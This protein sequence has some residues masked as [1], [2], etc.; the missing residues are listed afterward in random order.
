VRN[1]HGSSRQAEERHPTASNV[2]RNDSEAERQTQE[3][4][5]YTHAKPQCDSVIVCVC[6]VVLCGVCDYDSVCV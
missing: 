5:E 3:E 1:I 6:G 2:H 4:E